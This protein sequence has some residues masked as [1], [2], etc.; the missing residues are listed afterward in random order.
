MIEIKVDKESELIWIENVINAGKANFKYPCSLMSLGIS[1]SQEIKCI[2]S[3]A[4]EDDIKEKREEFK[5]RFEDRELSS[6]KIEDIL[7]DELF[8]NN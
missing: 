3:D 1:L 7:R 4:Y 8:S 2:P 5:K 6:N